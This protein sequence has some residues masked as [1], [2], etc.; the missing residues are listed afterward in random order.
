MAIACFSTTTSG[1]MTTKCVRI[2]R[3]MNL[4]SWINNPRL[5]VNQIIKEEVDALVQPDK[6]DTNSIKQVIKEYPKK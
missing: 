6:L 2:K 5:E 3:E 4:I 1:L